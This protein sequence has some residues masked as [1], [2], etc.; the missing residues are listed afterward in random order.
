MD[1]RVLR[2][3]PQINDTLGILKDEN[4]DFFSYTCE[5][6]EREKGHKVAK[7]TAIWDGRYKLGIR[8]ELT[9]LTKKHRE[10]YNKTAI[11]G[12]VE[13]W[14][15]FHIEILNIPDFT[16][17]YV[18]SGNTEAQTDAC[19]LLGDSANNNRFDK[20]RID[21]SLRAVKRF[22]KKYYPMLEEDKEIYINFITLK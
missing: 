1:L 18:H 2:Y 16:G 11:D 14:F 6:E 12:V 9:E 22:Y 15:K 10:V 7:E 3:S 8:K 4:A 13:E 21:N 5:D 20:G 19:L 17:V